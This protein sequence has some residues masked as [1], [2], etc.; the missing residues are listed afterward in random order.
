MANAFESAFPEP[1]QVLGVRLHP[2]SLGH[3]FK[4][5]RLGCA[6]VSDEVS[7]ANLGDLLLGISVCSMRSNPDPSRDE[8]WQWLNRYEPDGFFSKLGYRIR[9]RVAG[10]FGKKVFTAAERDMMALGRKLGPVDLPEKCRLF[11]DYVK[12]HST[13][14]DYWE[15]RSSDKKTGSHWAHC[16]TQT[17]ISKCGYT[18]EEVLNVPMSKA[19]SDFFQYLESEGNIRLM[20]EQ[21]ARFIH[22]V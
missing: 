10:W 15:E 2:F 4:L 17:L 14:P 18:M 3:Y 6:F 20:T 22:G 21:E 7:I 12:A 1:W 13:A 16:L 5:K 8:F 19:L 9:R 11:A